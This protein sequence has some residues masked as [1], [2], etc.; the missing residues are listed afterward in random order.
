MPYLMISFNGTLTNGTLTN[1]IF[2]IEQL[3][4]GSLSLRYFE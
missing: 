4:P 2:S 3:G 1:D